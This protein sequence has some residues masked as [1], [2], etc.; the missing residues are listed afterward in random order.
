MWTTLFNYFHT[1]QVCENSTNDIMTMLV[2]NFVMTTITLC[3][4]TLKKPVKVVDNRVDL[5]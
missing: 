5:Q 3:A 2:L 1:N 4:V